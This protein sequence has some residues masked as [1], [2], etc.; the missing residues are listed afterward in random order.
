MGRPTKFTPELQTRIVA[1]LGAG[2]YIETAASAA[3]V[4]KQTLY[5][6]LRQGAEGEE[7]FT[8]FLDAVERA[9][10]EAD[11]RDLK[12]IREAAHGGAWQAAAWRLERRHP[13]QWGR[14]RVEMTG[15]G[16]GL[17]GV[18]VTPEHASGT[19]VDLSLLSTEELDTYEQALEVLCAAVARSQGGE[20][21]HAAGNGR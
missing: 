16:G 2:A 10:G 18:D 1:F 12:T 13:D 20:L 6:W 15:A 5:T 3:G 17:V 19:E 9:Q 4:S 7:P 14:R 8:Q 11:I 21:V